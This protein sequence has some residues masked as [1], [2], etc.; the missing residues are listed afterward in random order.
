SSYPHCP[1]ARITRVN[2]HTQHYSLLF[3]NYRIDLRIYSSEIECLPWV[4]SPTQ[5]KNKP[6]PE[7]V[8]TY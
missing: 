6:T 3:K 2:H 5:A 8:I 7:A 4:Q 1:S